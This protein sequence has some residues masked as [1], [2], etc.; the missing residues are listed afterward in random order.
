LG[1]IERHFWLTRS[2]ARVMGLN[3]SECM[4]DG[5]LSE[6]GYATMIT[7]CRAGGCHTMCEA[8]LA[9][10]TDRPDHAPGHCANADL[11]DRL[12]QTPATAP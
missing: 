2:V 9:T 10:Q 12:Q 1:S 11:L 6:T 8:W 7:R 4:A 5:R 3:L